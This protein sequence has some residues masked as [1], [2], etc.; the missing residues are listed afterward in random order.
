LF[1]KRERPNYFGFLTNFLKIA[2]DSPDTGYEAELSE[3]V[4]AAFFLAADFGLS[5]AF[6][7]SVFF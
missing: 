5:E 2:L 4:L 3:G 6:E 7:S 1:V